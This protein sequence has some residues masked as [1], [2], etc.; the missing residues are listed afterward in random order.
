MLKLPFVLLFT[1]MTAFFWGIYGILLHNGTSLMGN[2]SLRAFVGVG[3]AYFLIAVLVPVSLLSAKK[4]QGYWSISGTILSLFAGS[5]GALGALG[6]ILALAFNAQPIYVMPIV[7]GGAPVVNTLVTSWINKSFN[8]IKPL[9]VIGLIMVIVGAVGV[10]TNKPALGGGG[11][12]GEVN[13]MA[14]IGSIAMAVVCWGAYGP[15]LHIGQTKMGGSRLRPFCCV[16]IAYF[17][18]AVAAPI[19]MLEAS[20]HEGSYTMMGMVW[21]IIAGAAG[22]MGALGI[23][24][25]FTYGGKPIMV[26]PLVFGFAPV[27]NTF[28]SMGIAMA[29]KDSSEILSKITSLFIGSLVLGIAGAVTVLLSAPKAKPH[30]PGSP[31]TPAKSE[32]SAATKSDSDSAASDQ[33]A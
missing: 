10:L 23:I 16:G 32:S 33:K 24:L 21:S 4:E 11:H 13:F 31:S 17:I 29:S 20:P 15:V 14:V 25:A 27:V 7:F 1:A 18:I 6:V 2:S 5:V 26:M 3:L 22:A 8:Q 9:F 28:T 30:A 12:G 19:V